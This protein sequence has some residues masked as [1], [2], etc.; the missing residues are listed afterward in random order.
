MQG[1]AQFGPY[2][3]KEKSEFIFASSD[4]FDEQVDRLRALR[5]GKF[6]Y[7]RN[8]N[9]D[10]SN[11]MAV[12]YREQMPMM[13][14]LNQLWEAQELEPNAAAWFKTPKPKEELYNLE[15]DPYE[16]NNLA[17]EVGL[18]DTLTFLRTQMDKWIFETQDLGEF[19]EKTLI[20]KW[21]PEGKRQKLVP[22]TTKIQADKIVLEHPDKGATIVWKKKS[23]YR[24]V[25]LL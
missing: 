11:A 9:P 19:S 17:S 24:L 22:V 7:I 16:L 5:F 15:Q 18:Q 3:V 2:E 23:R 20:N 1:K 8:F 21:F 4:R 25:N 12:S 14:Y 10:I 6:K 13:Q